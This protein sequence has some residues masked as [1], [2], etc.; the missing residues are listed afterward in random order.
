MS[1]R[2][3]CT[4]RSAAAP[5]D[6]SSH[7]DQRRR[8]GGGQEPG[9]RRARP[10]VSAPASRFPDAAATRARSGRL[11]RRADQS[12]GLGYGRGGCVVLDGDCRPPCPA[13]RVKVAID[14]RLRRYHRRSG[15]RAIATRSA[16]AA[17]GSPQPLRP[18]QQKPQASRKI[19]DRTV[20]NRAF[21]SVPGGRV[22]STRRCAGPP[23]GRC[24]FVN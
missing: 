24:L 2:S 11:A 15:P 4:L 14:A 16:A 9:C 3:H 10:T 22:T 5:G 12:K 18:A 20:R 21:G 13:V 19:S 8:Q 7:V 1:A 6:T 23:L 17:P